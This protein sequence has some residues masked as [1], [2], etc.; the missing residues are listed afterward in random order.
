MKVDAGWQDA[1]RRQAGRPRSPTSAQIAVAIGS[2]FGLEQHRH[3]RHRQRRRPPGRERRRRRRQHDPDRRPDQ[4]GQLG[5]RPG[6]P[7]RRGDRD[8]RRDLQPERREQRHRLRHPDRRPPR[9]S[10]TRSPAASSLARA[11]ASASSIQDDP[12]GRRRRLVAEVTGGRRRRQGRPPG[13]RPHHRRRRHSR[14]QPLD[15][16]RGRIGAHSPATPSPSTSE[17]DGQTARST[18][19]ARHSA[20]DRPPT[21][22]AAPT[23]AGR[24]W[25]RAGPPP[26]GAL[27]PD[28]GP[29]D[30]SD[31]IAHPAGMRLLASGRLTA[32]RPP[33]ARVHRRRRPSLGPCRAGPWAIE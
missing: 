27:Q 22:P 12:D 9:P 20:A 7:Q 28:P 24:S 13:R 21:T 31:R 25:P 30:P 4:P 14:S 10:P 32:S 8:Q 3:R 18:V 26:S 17:R 2:P 1:H 29:A 15:D 11:L 23:R 5:R 6:Q 16:L 33:P 19:Q